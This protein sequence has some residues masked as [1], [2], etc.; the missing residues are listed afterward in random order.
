MM[1]GLMFAG[2]DPTMA[3][4][5]QIV[6]MFMLIATTGF[7]TMIASYLVYKKFYNE[8]WQLK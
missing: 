1:S 4:R 5:Y 7:S 2:I 3:I 6:V 8:Q